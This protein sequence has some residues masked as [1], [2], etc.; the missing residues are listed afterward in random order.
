MQSDPDSKQAELSIRVHVGDFRVGPGIAHEYQ[1]V[2]QTRGWS[3]G[4]VTK[5]CN[6]SRQGQR[7]LAAQRLPRLGEDPIVAEAEPPPLLSGLPADHLH[8]SLDRK[9]SPKYRGPLFPSAVNPPPG[10]FLL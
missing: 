3:I 5:S 2:V 4:H 6:E 1:A 8:L 9:P 7:L 10:L